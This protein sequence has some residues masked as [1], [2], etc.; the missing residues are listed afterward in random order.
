MYGN[1][2]NYLFIFGRELGDVLYAVSIRVSLQSA[3]T[4][5]H[6][7]YF[8]SRRNFYC[9]TIEAFFLDQCTTRL[10]K[11]TRASN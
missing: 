3:A 6:R 9:Q 5:S 4:G 2:V 10:A 8:D 7:A 11:P 1:L